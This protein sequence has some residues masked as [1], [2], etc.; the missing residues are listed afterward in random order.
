MYNGNQV[1]STREGFPGVRLGGVGMEEGSLFGLHLKWTILELK[2]NPQA[3]AK[4]SASTNWTICCLPSICTS[5]AFS[6]ENETSAWRRVHASKLKAL[7]F[8]FYHPLMSAPNC[9]DCEMCGEAGGAAERGVSQRK[10]L[11][12]DQDVFGYLPWLWPRSQQGH[13][14]ATFPL[15]QLSDCTSRLRCVS[16]TDKGSDSFFSW[17]WPPELKAGWRCVHVGLDSDILACTGLVF[18]PC[19]GWEMQLVF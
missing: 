13:V 7:L 4:S 1:V 5:G 10:K 9:L 18:D 6:K 16:T 11:D 15:L 2:G 17:W 8:S 14:W 19:S 3:W 12:P